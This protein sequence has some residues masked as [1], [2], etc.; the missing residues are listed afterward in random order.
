MQRQRQSEMALQLMESSMEV[1]SSVDTHG[2][3]IVARKL[4]VIHAPRYLTQEE[5]KEGQNPPDF[6]GTMFAL[7]YELA[8]SRKSLAEADNQHVEKLRKVVMLRRERDSLLPALYGHFAATRQTVEQLFGKGKS[9]EIAGIDGPTSQKPKKLLRQTGFLTQHLE[10]PELELPAVEIEGFEIHPQRVA[11]GLRA[12]GDR[13]EAVYGEL[14]VLRREAQESRKVKVR[15]LKEHQRTFLWTA[16]TLEGFYR[17][18]GEDELADLIRPSTRQAGRRAVEV[19]D[20]E[21]GAEPSAAE[22]SPATEADQTESATDQTESATEESTDSS[23][24]T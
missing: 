10:N 23:A 15:K 16:R 18:A 22:N 21:S 2:V 1:E 11:Q 9:F 5:G 4:D 6:G 20:E 14:R 8:D 19:K 12:K 24:T 3:P 7:K 13:L 17:L